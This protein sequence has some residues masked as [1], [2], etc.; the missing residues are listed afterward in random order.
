MPILLTTP[1]NPGDV[2]PGAT[3]AEAKI[4]EFRIGIEHR[5]RIEVL[6]ELGNT[7]D[8]EWVPGKVPAHSVLIEDLRE[9]TPYTDVIMANPQLYGGMALVLYGLVQLFDPVLEGEYQ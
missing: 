5:K 4:T 8:G 3:Y 2:D 6:V 1:F 7:V 9:S